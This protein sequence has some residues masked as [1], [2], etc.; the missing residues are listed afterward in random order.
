MTYGKKWGTIKNQNDKPEAFTTIKIFDKETRKLQA[1]TITDEK[2]RY[3]L[4]L[5]PGYYDAEVISVNGN[6]ATLKD[7]FLKERD[8]FMM[9]VRLG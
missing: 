7:I 1:R 6:I 3:F 4:I 2:G 8:V 5:D 9:D